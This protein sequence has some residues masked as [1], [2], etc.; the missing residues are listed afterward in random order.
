MKLSV[1]HNPPQ[2]IWDDLVDNSHAATAFHT[3]CWLDSQAGRW[4]KIVLANRNSTALAGI[5]IEDT[6]YKAVHGHSITPY[7][8]PI[9]RNDNLTGARRSQY[10]FSLVSHFENA[11]STHPRISFMTSPWL[12]DLRAFVIARW[13]V[14]LLYT[15]VLNAEQLQDIDNVI[16]PELRRKIRVVRDNIAAVE[17]YDKPPNDIIQTTLDLTG[18][19]Y[20]RQGLQVRFNQN[21]AATSF[22]SMCDKGHG[23]FVTVRE[24]TGDISCA[25]GVFEFNHRAHFLISGH[26]RSAATPSAV[27]LAVYEA[28]RHATRRG[29]KEFDF[30]GSFLGGVDHFFRQFGGIPVPFY[31]VSGP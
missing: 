6:A 10:H 23:F 29:A 24:K 5:A 12:D 30:E 3:S 26:N 21:E 18:R 25:V 22:R 13:K 15:N 9:L 8:G 31:E 11:L 1:V 27:A 2:D 19:C 20:N 7:E 17:I 14:E 16:D 4:K 28:I